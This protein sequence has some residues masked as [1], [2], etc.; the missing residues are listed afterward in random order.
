MGWWMVVR[1]EWEMILKIKRQQNNSSF[2]SLY[3]GGIPGRRDDAWEPREVG[4]QIVDIRAGAGTEETYGP[5]TSVQP[6][7]VFS[8]KL[9]PRVPGLA[10]DLWCEG[11][12]QRP[13]LESK[14]LRH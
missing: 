11:R 6:G 4:Q 8:L 12:G 10:G 1:C 13:D 7:K 14:M 2:L 3:S 9:L 5:G